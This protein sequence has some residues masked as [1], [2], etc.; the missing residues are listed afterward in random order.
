[1]VCLVDLRLREC[2]M[3][4]RRYLFPYKAAIDSVHGSNNPDNGFNDS[5]MEGSERIA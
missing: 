2:C 4:V 5:G 1:M 3:T